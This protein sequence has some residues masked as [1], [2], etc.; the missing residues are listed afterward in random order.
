MSILNKPHGSRWAK[1]LWTVLLGVTFIAALLQTTILT[2]ELS[3][4]HSAW[5][6]NTIYGKGLEDPLA[7]EMLKDWADV[8]SSFRPAW[9]LYRTPI[10]LYLGTLMAFLGPVCCIAAKHHWHRD[11][12]FTSLTMVTLGVA[13]FHLWANNPLTDS[14]NFML[15]PLLLFPASVLIPLWIC[16]LIA[17]RF[18]RTKTNEPITG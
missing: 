7:N 1:W 18:H 8:P 17:E 6:L 13:A 14:K 5:Y 12:W 4:H 2:S 9:I 10:S 15:W 11:A 16:T 3:R